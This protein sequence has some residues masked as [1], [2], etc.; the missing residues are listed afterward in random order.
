MEPLTRHSEEI[1]D[2]FSQLTTIE[3]SLKKVAATQPTKTQTAQK[4]LTGGQIKGWLHIS[5]RTLQ[6]LRDNGLIPF[7]TIGPRIILYPQQDILKML[8]DNYRP[9][10]RSTK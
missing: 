9:L 3:Q 8:E 2:L 7:T 4:Y 1:Q 10:Y 6:N 5:Q